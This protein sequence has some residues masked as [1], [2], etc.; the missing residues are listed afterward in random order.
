M[1]RRVAITGL[2]AVTPVGNDVKATWES[3]VAGRSGIARITGFDAET[4]PVRIAGEV[5]GFSLEPYLKDRSQRRY[6]SRAAGFGVAATVQALADAGINEAPYDPHERGVAMGGTVGRPGLQELVDIGNVMRTTERRELFRQAPRDV[7][8]RDQNLAMT[9]MARLGGCQGPMIS[10]STACTASAHAIGEAFRRIQEGESRLMIAGGY[11]ALTTFLDVLGF[12]LLGALAK[13]YDAHPE[14]A[15]RPF[16]AGRS[17]FVL[18]EGAVVAILE[19]WDGA[20]ARGARIYAELAGYGSSLNAYRMTDAP[21]DGGGAIL[22]VANALK[23][24]RLRPDEVDYVSAHGTSTPGN[25]LC[26]TMAIKQVFGQSAYRLAI[27]SVKSMTG[28]LTA[29][30]GGLNLLAAVCALRDQ[31]VPPTIN[32]EHP[33]P[34]LDLDYVPN[35]ARQ[36]RVRASLINAF[37]FGGTNACL[38]VREPGTGAGVGR[39]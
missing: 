27:S 19:D 13:D 18:G 6:L 29:A 35:S 33:D 10:V 26:E 25:D 7:M 5:K 39:A 1:H 36:T 17:G 37:A 31:V 9:V 34:E 11:D 30:A 12:G 20:R 14:K 16:D 2:G 24:S 3:L 15:S 38:V 23:E 28:H 21:P 32:Y 4:F 8:V 22:A